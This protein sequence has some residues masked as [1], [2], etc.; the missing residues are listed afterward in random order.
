MSDNL[1]DISHDSGWT[2]SP[3]EVELEI[4]MDTL[5]KKNEYQRNFIEFLKGW[6]ELRD[7]KMDAIEDKVRE[8][9][10]LCNITPIDIIRVARLTLQIQR[11]MNSYKDKGESPTTNRNSDRSVTHSK[12][13]ESSYSSVPG[14][15]PST[16]PMSHFERR[17]HLRE[18]I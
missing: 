3:K 12:T 16:P 4:Q 13:W 9:S 1:G 14:T 18:T 2:R 5:R 10:W 11:E 15:L 17:Q 7:Q 6:D 8:L